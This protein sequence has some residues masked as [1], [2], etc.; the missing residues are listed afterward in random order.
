MNGLLLHKRDSQNV[1]NFIWK[2]FVLAWCLDALIQNCILL[3]KLMKQWCQ[4]HF[5]IAISEPEIL[6]LSH[7]A[8][9]E[10]ALSIQ[11]ND[12]LAEIL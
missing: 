11:N 10:S 2:V 6:S 8:Y 4:P 3:G 1:S 7:T 12:H 5:D 9:D